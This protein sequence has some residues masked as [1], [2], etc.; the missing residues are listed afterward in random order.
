MTT[1]CSKIGVSIALRMV[2][3]AWGMDYHD[4][5]GLTTIPTLEERRKVMR[6]CLL[7]KIFNDICYFTPDTFTSSTSV[8]HHA[9]HSMTLREPFCRTN[10]YKYSFGPFTI[11]L[12]N[13][14]DPTTVSAPT[15][16][17]FKHQLYSLY[18]I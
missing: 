2:Y 12:W 5:I 7:Y 6:L 18:N 1:N 13:N 15:L 17:C 16:A 14:L 9:S 3:H 4:L 8:S 10:G 11:N